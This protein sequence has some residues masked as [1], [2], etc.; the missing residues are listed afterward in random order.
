MVQYI[1]VG[2][3]MHNQR[4]QAMQSIVTAAVVT[5]L[6]EVQP[7]NSR[8]TPHTEYRPQ[9]D[10]CV[11]T[12]HHSGAFLI[13]SA[14]GSS[15][16]SMYCSSNTDFVPATY[17]EKRIVPQTFTQYSLWAET[18]E[19]SVTPSACAQ[20]TKA[21]LCPDE[22]ETPLFIV[23]RPSNALF[24]CR[25]KDG[26]F[27]KSSAD[28]S[29]GVGCVEC[30][31]G[32]F[33]PIHTNM[34]F[35]C[36]PNTKLL[37]AS[38]ASRDGVRRFLALSAP[39]A[40]C[41]ADQGYVIR[42]AHSDINALLRESRSTASSKFEFYTS[43]P[44]TT[45][46]C[47][48]RSL[49]DVAGQLMRFAGRCPSG[50]FFGTLA[51]TNKTVPSCQMCPAD[52]YCV[53]DQRTACRLHQKTY[54][55]GHSSEDDCR[56]APGS[57]KSATDRLTC[58][59]ITSPDFYSR[60]CLS[61]SDKTCGVKLH[62]PPGHRCY[63]GS[64]VLQCGRGEFLDSDLQQCV[65]CPLGFYCVEGAVLRRCPDGATTSQIRGAHASDCFCVA[66]LFQTAIAGTAQGF[67]CQSQPAS[68]TVPQ[69]ASA[70]GVSFS[71]TE[72]SRAMAYMTVNILFSS[73]RVHHRTA[74]N[75]IGTVL[76]FD[77]QRV[78]LE[79]HLFVHSIQNND[80]SIATS[81]LSLV[82]TIAGVALEP[83]NT[84]IVLGW[85]D[86][87]ALGQGSVAIYVML[88]DIQKG[89]VLR[90]LLQTSHNT[91]TSEL[92]V[93]AQEW[94]RMWEFQPSSYYTTL[95]LPDHFAVVAYQ[96]SD[97]AE[98]QAELTLTGQNITS[99]EQPY[100]DFVK[101]DLLTGRVRTT[102]ILTNKSI[103][104]T[105]FNP[106]TLKTD[107]E[108]TS[109]S[110]CD[111]P[112]P[113]T[114][115]LGTELARIDIYTWQLAVA[116]ATTAASS[117]SHTESP[118]GDGRTKMIP[119]GTQLVHVSSTQLV[120]YRD[121]YGM[122]PLV[123]F[124]DIESRSFGV[125]HLDYAVC[126]PGKW[127]NRDSFFKCVCRPGYKPRARSMS[128]SVIDASSDD[129]VLCSNTEV[130]SA[131][132]P[133]TANASKC[134][135]GYKL[136]AG[137]SCV[138]CGNDEF[139]R[140]SRGNAC[141]VNSDTSQTK[142]AVDVSA[143]VC[144]PGYHYRDSLYG[145]CEECRKPF[146]CTDSRMHT[147]PRNTSTVVD[148]AGNSRLC[149]CWP[150]FYDLG[151]S[152]G[153]Q[154][155]SVTLQCG[156]TPIG[157]YN[158]PGGIRM[159]PAL[160]TT[161]YTQSTSV[162]QC[163][164]A[165]G[166][167]I[168]HNLSSIDRCVSCVLGEVCTVAS[169]GIVGSCTP[170]YKQIANQ[171]HDACVCEAGFYDEM[172]TQEGVMRC[173][174]CPAGYYCPQERAAKVQSTVIQCPYKTTSHPGTPSQ[175]GCF[176]KQSDRN[177]MTSPVAPFALRCLCASTHYESVENMCTACPTNMFVSVQT[178]FSSVVMLPRVS[179]CSCV[180]GFYRQELIFMGNNQASASCI[181]C[182]VGHICPVGQN[183]VG[184]T[185]CPM[186]TFGPSI[187]QGNERGCLTCPVASK[188]NAASKTPNAASKTPNTASNTSDTASNT[189]D[190]ASNTST[191][192][193]NTST[194]ASNTSTTTPN[195]S[196]TASNTSTTASNTSNTAP[197]TTP[198]TQLSLQG[199]VIDCFLEFTP[200]FSSRELEFDMCTFVFVVFSDDVMS[201]EIA[202][203]ILR[204]FR[205]KDASVDVVPSLKRIQYS[206]TLT[207]TFF[208]DI[209]FVISQM[210]A[211]WSVIRSQSQDNP[212]FYASMVRYVFCDTMLRIADDLHATNVDVAVCYLSMDRM[213][214]VGKL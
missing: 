56:C 118:C 37:M 27:W 13:E 123:I 102:Q 149:R 142:G 75:I 108:Q 83:L 14:G 136:H 173:I 59:N 167:K 84:K 165:G 26:Y 126:T 113:D 207:H 68:H 182:P 164:C 3:L 161:Q 78:S 11:Q 74:G 90:G 9:K 157:F 162:S 131:G 47:F 19:N 87:A 33:C 67:V 198:N 6:M 171:Q 139:C 212:T 160:H 135:P 61:S 29:A 52:S 115:E 150:G 22:K 148:K 130:C 214:T 82:N 49:C 121:V 189:S 66:P 7:C 141:P 204:I 12:L 94:V 163:V 42:H 188:S 129:C 76:V 158:T 172:A 1:R 36:P 195:T 201:D 24:E 32:Q 175:S 21:A 181:I 169:R 178:M 154:N 110:F 202:S 101:L 70:R 45:P 184:P 156:E 111:P 73:L 124:Q 4:W 176:C 98:I 95:A 213:T 109:V 92:Y 103:A 43:S 30:P 191:T 179:A 53:D 46:S 65:A 210:Y 106:S 193:S 40:Y 64:V 117:S 38:A 197:N 200:V 55:V 107:T 138:L 100:H 186:G 85:M 63:R 205:H 79:V 50:Q 116:N 145:I 2:V 153:T 146:Y 20:Q 137:V 174:P 125:L 41:Q 143:C 159:C 89:L 192:A 194:T 18:P 34:H 104:A 71:D 196:T 183:D 5:L 99:E 151:L 28:D 60:A 140:H 69:T 15:Q 23:D 80:V 203:A 17:G 133:V 31:A 57:Y 211:N 119:Q 58:I 112:A 51:D 166:Y 77:S 128:G 44:C 54:G 72:R 91:N 190:T 16:R 81:S 114:G 96:A 144:K 147:C 62:C 39:D 134:A 180:S 93:T 152:T 88:M 25:C 155:D 199:S 206:V 122:S 170:Y 105:F 208:L 48:E 127:A 97:T 10:V 86:F 8:Y 209:L 35:S 132:T 185:P 168:N 177:L 187:G 120:A